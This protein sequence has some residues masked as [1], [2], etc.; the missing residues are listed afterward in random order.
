[1]PAIFAN[2]FVFWNAITRFNLKIFYK[3]ELDQVSDRVEFKGEF[4]F[5]LTS[6]RRFFSQAA[7]VT[8]IALSACG[9][10]PSS[11]PNALSSQSNSVTPALGATYNAEVFVYAADGITLLGQGKTDAKTGKSNVTL[12]GYTS[13]TPV[14]VKVVVGPGA[15]YYDETTKTDVVI[16][17]GTTPFSMLSI[18]PSATAGQDFSANP[19]TNMA[20]KFAGVAA[21][22]LGTTKLSTP[23]V[24]DKVY[25][26]VAKT[27]LALGLPS[28]TNVLA[29]VTPATK[30]N[31]NPTGKI[32]N[33]LVVMA[34]AQIGQVNTQVVK[35]P[36]QRALDLVNA[37]KLDGTIDTT[38]STFNELNA[39]L[40]KETNLGIIVVEPKTTIDETTL[41]AAKE[42]ARKAVSKFTGST[43]GGN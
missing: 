33:L 3:F 18:L 36:I 29:P 10:S 6:N 4:M 5:K 26:G 14:I 12:T 28:D 17:A 21:D 7:I 11:N 25:E 41:K 15:S 20:A 2:C 37:I 40:K 23:L 8:A 38:K 22:K 30:A 34:T 39:A 43:T 35:D 16:A 27:N 31:P 13:G 24:A 32:S 1:M 42:E 9:G 19:L